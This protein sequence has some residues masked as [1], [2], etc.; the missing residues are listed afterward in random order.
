MSYGY[1]FAVAGHSRRTIYSEDKFIYSGGM[2]PNG[3]GVMNGST[4]DPTF[5]HYEAGSDHMMNLLFTYDE[6][7]K[8]TG[9]LV[10]VPCPRP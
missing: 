3:H 6:N 8:L 9:I 7:D 10:N 5:S 4:S 1:G 2:A